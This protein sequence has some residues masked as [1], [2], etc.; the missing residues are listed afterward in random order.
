[1]ETE[2]TIQQAQALLCSGTG[3]RNEDGCGVYE[4]VTS[5]VTAENLIFLLEFGKH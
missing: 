4:H 3:R 5:E 2:A 1:M